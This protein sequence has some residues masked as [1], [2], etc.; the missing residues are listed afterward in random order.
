MR[1]LHTL[2]EG[3]KHIF[4][5]LGDRFRIDSADTGVQRRRS[6]CE[7][8]LFE[9]CQQFILAVV[10]AER[11]ASRPNHSIIPRTATESRSRS[12]A[13]TKAGHWSHYEK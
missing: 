9:T 5:E 10:A 7:N 1:L 11:A 4:M 13:S 8:L 12:I 3:R 2:A 6:N